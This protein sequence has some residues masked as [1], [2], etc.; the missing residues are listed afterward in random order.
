MQAIDVWPEQGRVGRVGSLV[1]V[2]V[3]GDTPGELYQ[4]T[5]TPRYPVPLVAVVVTG[6]H[7]GKVI[8]RALAQTFA[9]LADEF[10]LPGPEILRAPLQ[11]VEPRPN[12]RII[13][14]GER[15][16]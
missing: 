11:L 8:V 1:A 16:L 13:S 4:L 9:Q 3:K 7:W 12:V 15:A 6:D 10:E 14:D 5:S 2:L